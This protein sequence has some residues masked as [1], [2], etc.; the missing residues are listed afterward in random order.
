MQHGARFTSQQRGFVTACLAFA[1]VPVRPAARALPQVQRRR[2]HLGVRLPVR[3]IVGEERAVAVGRQQSG[4]ECRRLV[5]PRD[6]PQ[7]VTPDP[8]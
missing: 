4:Q 6:E 1:Q 8:P 5:E 3:A 7:S 2:E